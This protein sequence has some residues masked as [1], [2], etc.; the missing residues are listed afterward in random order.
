MRSVLELISKE[1]MEQLALPS[2]LRYGKAIFERGG[3]EIIELTPQ[4][5]EGWIGGLSGSSA[6]GGGQRRRTQLIATPE[7]LE[8]HCAG[9]PKNHQIF[10]KHCV[11][12]ALFLLKEG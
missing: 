4:K 2:N 5:A 7:G 10:C 12:L 1:I 11:A 9:N 3:I 8:W 6:E